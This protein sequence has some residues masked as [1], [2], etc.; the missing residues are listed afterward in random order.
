[1]RQKAEI[2]S[3]VLKLHKKAKDRS[4]NAAQQPQEQVRYNDQ[5][6]HWSGKTFTMVNQTVYNGQPNHWSSKTFTMVNQTVYN[7]QPNSLQ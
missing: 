1:M 4:M 2:A 7:G 6:N 3:E 5:P